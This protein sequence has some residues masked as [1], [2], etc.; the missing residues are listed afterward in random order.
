MCECVWEVGGRGIVFS[1]VWL[2]IAL[3]RIV[4]MCCLIKYYFGVGFYSQCKY[5]SM[6]TYFM[7]I[8]NNIVF[9]FPYWFVFVW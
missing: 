2:V 1:I 9:F 8:L 5:S 7:C 4:W 6:F 3:F